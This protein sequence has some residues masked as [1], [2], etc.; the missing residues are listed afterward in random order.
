MTRVV[1]TAAI[2]ALALAV[3]GTG[4]N[5]S[6]TSQTSVKSS[7]QAIPQRTATQVVP[8]PKNTRDIDASGLLE[9][10]A[11]AGLTAE[12]LGPAQV[13]TDHSSR[14]PEPP[15]STLWLR[16]SDGQGN[17]EQMTFVEFGSWKTAA[18]V[19]AKPINGFAVR[20]WY[21]LGIVSNHFVSA[22]THAVDG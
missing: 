12:E 9:E 21:V 1:S 16:I 2:V 13:S 22:V 6:E 17:S 15:R 5:S 20:N 7:V 11:A 8:R 18:E 14:F 4:C 10:L 19:D 3:L